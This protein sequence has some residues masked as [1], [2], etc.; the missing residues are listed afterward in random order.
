VAHWPPIGRDDLKQAAD[1]DGFAGVLPQLVRRLIAETADGLTE[2][3]MPGEG[4]VAMGGFDGVVAADRATIEVPSGTSVWELSV[5]KSCGKKADDDYAKRLVGP[6]GGPTA[7]V[8]YVQLILTPWKGAST[9]AVQRSK[10]GRW[11]RVRGLNL[12]AVRGWLDRAPA[13]AVWLAERLGKA[14]PGTRLADD[15]FERTWLPSTRPSLGPDAVLAGR[16]EAAP[17]LLSCLAAGRS[18]VTIA[19]DLGTDEFRAF[20]AA[21]AE[22]AEEPQREALKA[23]TLFVD[24]AA[25]LSRLTALPQ[26][27]VLVLADARLAASA[28]VGGPHQIVVLSPP[29]GDADV[30]V[31]RVDPRTVAGLLAAAGEPSERA[32][33]LGA[34]ARR[35]VSALRRILAVHPATLRPAWAD[36]P[37]V[38]RRRLLLLGGWH[39]AHA[40]DRALVERITDRP[41]TDA[42]DAALALAGSTDTPMLGRLDDSWYVVSPSDAW[43]LL[44]P[45]MTRDDLAELHAAAVEVLTE[46]DPLHGLSATDALRAQMDGR[47]RRY[48]SALRRGLARSLALLGSTADPVPAT[49]ATTGAEH[50]SRAVRDVLKAATTDPTYAVWTGLRPVLGELAEAAPEE[51]L[52][53]MREGLRGPDALDARMFTDSDSSAGLLGPPAGNSECLWALET[54]AWSPEYFDDAV[55]V[56]A[57]LAELDP[58]GRYSNRPAR[59]LTD[60]FS[61]WHPTTSTDEQ[62]RELALRRLLRHRP[63]VAKTLLVDLIPDGNEIRMDHSGPRFRD[64]KREPVLTRA[65]VVRNVRAVGELLLQSVSE[66]RAAFL[67]A[68]GK[69]DHLAPEQRL[70]L[71]ERL[72]TLGESLADEADRAALSEALRATAARHREYAATAWALP[73]NEIAPVEAAATALAPRDPVHRHGWLF[74]QDWIKTGDPSRRDDRKAYDRRVQQMRADAAAEVLAEQGLGGIE[75][76]ATGTQSPHLIGAA[77]ADTAAPALD[78]DM[79]GWLEQDTPRP[80]V[81]YAYLARR[82]PV[83]DQQAVDELLAAAD[84]PRAKAAV[85]RAAGDPPSTWARLDVLGDDVAQAYW[86]GFSIYGL[87]DFQAVG[88]AAQGLMSVGRF[89]AVLALVCLYTEHVDSPE[90]AVLAATACEELLAAGRPDPELRALSGHDFRTVVAL[91]HRHRK[92]LG[93]RRLVNIEWQ[94]FPAL[95]FDADAPALHEAL[96]DDPTF[97]ADIVELVWPSDQGT[98]S[99]THTGP[100]GTDDAGDGS[101]DETESACG[102]DAQAVRQEM[103]GRAYEVLHSWRRVPGAGPDGVIDTQQLDAWVDQARRLLA[104]RHRLAHGDRTIGEVLAHAL[105]DPDGAAPPRAVRDLLERIGSDEIDRGLDLGIYNRRGITSRG[106][107]DGGDQERNL[108]ATFREQATS[109]TAWPRTRWLLRR[110]TESYEREA[111]LNDEEAERCRRGLDG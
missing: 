80:D 78:A 110:L 102:Q 81:A 54:L 88:Q 92:E 16:D 63:G 24:D 44:Q 95:G 83:A 33:D 74:I 76:L 26:P 48:S 52:D 111:R 13:T 42:Q 27:L 75:T 97:F 20:V 99:G 87:G 5:E 67:A 58:G 57:A 28:P 31:G 38:V 35:S 82:I 17:T 2:L 91:L 15:W 40:A 4:G 11:K 9:W 109:A 49:G 79:L 23:R 105:P 12:D 89:A 90:G 45:H 96:S 1:S 7:D 100:T 93:L 25:A 10:E 36:G 32:D 64:W 61:C 3:D 39:G 103:A 22:R 47:R 71:C 34:L 59:S 77:L 55:D 46:P 53:A 84:S 37:D 29:G 107:F 85:L 50:A 104:E 86:Q 56:L 14:V 43:L 8:T 19:G 69:I 21:T 65:D 98:P 68:I 106:M 94:L 72:S 51:F 60:I 6:G 101:V 73:A 18:A 30:E 41:W 108:A 62:Q 70:A 66:D